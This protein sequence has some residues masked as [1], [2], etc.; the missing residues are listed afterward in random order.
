MMLYCDNQAAI[1]IAHNPVQHD[2]TKHIEVDRHFIRERVTSGEV[3][4]PYISSD[5]QLVD[6]LTKGVA[7]NKLENDLR[8]LGMYDIY[9]QLEGE[10]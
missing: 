2:R 1:N 8:K 9:S 5:L 6:V 10:C 7:K 3:C 4:L